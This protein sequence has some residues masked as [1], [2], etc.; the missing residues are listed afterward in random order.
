M[1]TELVLI[2]IAAMKDG[3][4]LLVNQEPGSDKLTFPNVSLKQEFFLRGG[5]DQILHQLLVTVPQPELDN[6]LHS[7][8][9]KDR[10]V[11]VYDRDLLFEQ[12]HSMVIVRAIALPQEFSLHAKGIWL[13]AETL[14]SQNSR[15]S[16]DNRLFLQECLNQIPRWVKNTTFIFELI[17]QVFSIQDLRLLIGILSHQEIDPGNF[18]RRLKRLQILNPRVAGQQRIHKWEFSWEK[19]NVLLTEGLLP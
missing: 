6:W 10:I 16:P 12:V 19:S 3:L 18:H 9:C 2:P 14:F 1:K 13:N 11:D 17:S 8:R 7:S 4:Q 15:L 5:L